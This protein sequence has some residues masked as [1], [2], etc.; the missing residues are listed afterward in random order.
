MNKIFLVLASIFISICA[1]ASDRY[2]F[3]TNVLNINEVL[4]GKRIYKN[5]AVYVDRVVAVNGGAPAGI[6]DIYSPTKNEL[7]IPSV[8]VG[9]LTYSN[10]SITVGPIL[11]VGGFTDT[12]IETMPQTDPGGT[13]VVYNQPYSDLPDNVSPNDATISYYEDRR[14]SLIDRRRSQDR[15]FAIKPKGNAQPFKLELSSANEAVENELSYGYI[16]SYLYYDKGSLKYNGKA[17]VGRFAKD[18]TDETL[19][20]THSTGKSINSYILGHAICEGYITSIDETIDWPLM[21]KTLYQGQSL[22]NLLNM[23]AGDKHTVDASSSYV[24]GSTTHHRDLGLDTIAA[25]LEGTKKIG[26]ELF[27]NN[28]MA[29][30]LANYIVFKA[31]DKYEELMQKVFQ[32]KVKIQYEVTY[33]KHKKTE[34]NSKFSEYYGQPQT[35]ASYSYYMTRMDTLRLAEAMMKDYQSQTCVGQYLKT[36]QDQA[37]AWPSYRPTNSNAW[38]RLSNYSNK[39]GAQFYFDFYEMSGRN[40]FGTTGYNGQ[41]MMIDMDNSRIIV[42]NSAATAWDQK[43]FLLN[44][45]KDGQLPK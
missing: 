37:V 1:K 18:I 40:I 44:V 8:T 5:V 21:I 17:K 26:S 23:S 42:T 34:T 35:L 3:S 36:I 30:V 27:Y 12:T 4:V 33:E 39:Y 24:M 25:S 38:L 7:F 43:S 20:A 22:R 6:R 45:I 2:D 41:N 16:L 28:F 13:A 14:A 19:F 15:L 29:D 10:V 32:D 9:N 11:S 31:G